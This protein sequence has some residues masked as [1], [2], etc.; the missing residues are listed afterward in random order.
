MPDLS[1]WSEQHA[2]KSYGQ[3]KNLIPAVERN[4]S[5]LEIAN[6]DLRSAEPTVID[7]ILQGIELALR[8]IELAVPSNPVP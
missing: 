6:F 4:G 1:K 7:S 2:G 8:R 5:G 3:P